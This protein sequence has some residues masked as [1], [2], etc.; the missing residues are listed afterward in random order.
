MLRSLRL[1]TDNTISLN[2]NSALL[3]ADFSKI[4]S[5]GP[6]WLNC[7]MRYDAASHLSKNIIEILA[8]RTQ[9]WHAVKSTLYCK[10]NNEVSLESIYPVSA[11]I[12]G[13]T[14]VGVPQTVYRGPSTMVARPKSPNFRD[15]LPSWCSYT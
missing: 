14:Y 13:A 12:S 11:M 6:F 7:P 3:Q 9:I 4:A 1:T 2:T 10:Q 8:A 15:L 5:R